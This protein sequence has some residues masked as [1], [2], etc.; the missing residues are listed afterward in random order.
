M[1]IGPGSPNREDASDSVDPEA[2]PED[3]GPTDCELNVQELENTL[4]IVG[5]K[6]YEANRELHYLRIK[7]K[8]GSSL[9][10]ETL[11]TAADLYDD[12][13]I[14][15]AGG[16]WEFNLGSLDIS[17]DD[18]RWLCDNIVNDS[19]PDMDLDGYG[20][21]EWSLIHRWGGARLATEVDAR[22]VYYLSFI[23]PGDY[24]SEQ[25]GPYL[26]IIQGGLSEQKASNLASL[27]GVQE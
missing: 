13:V 6:L 11:G 18:A 23:V 2:V 24:A 8:V 27:F 22:A 10:R 5:S 15:E 7:A 25:F 21:M 4:A 16:I 19:W 20:D 1:E 12:A 17:Q 9:I 3:S 14:E 26:N